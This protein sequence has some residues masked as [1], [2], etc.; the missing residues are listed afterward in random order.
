VGRPIRHSVASCCGASFF[1]PSKVAHVF[2]CIANAR[3]ETRKP[4]VNQG[5]LPDHVEHCGDLFDVFFGVSSFPSTNHGIDI[6]TPGLLRL[7]LL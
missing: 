1:N 3:S 2:G 5:D 6:F 4:N 7:A